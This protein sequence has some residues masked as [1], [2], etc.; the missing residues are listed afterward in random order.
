MKEAERLATRSSDPSQLIFAFVWHTA[1]D[2]RD[3]EPGWDQAPPSSP[4]RAYLFWSGQQVNPEK[5]AS[6]ATWL[7]GEERL[8]CLSAEDTSVIANHVN[9]WTTK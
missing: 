2:L 9:G 4:R 7:G 8:I 6:L 5:T 1:I 3:A